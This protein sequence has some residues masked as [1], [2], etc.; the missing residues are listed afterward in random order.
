M[1]NLIVGFP[2]AVRTLNS[3]GPDVQDPS[4]NHKKGGPI[5][6]GKYNWV[7]A[8]RSLQLPYY[9]AATVSQPCRAKPDQQARF[10]Q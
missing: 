10:K 8:K 7:R 9:C 5:G 4:R 1:T 3:Y 2:K 6:F